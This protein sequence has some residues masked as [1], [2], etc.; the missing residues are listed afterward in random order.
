MGPEPFLKV[1]QL[2]VFLRPE[3]NDRVV[4]QIFLI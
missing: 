3:L 4:D 1:P 2:K